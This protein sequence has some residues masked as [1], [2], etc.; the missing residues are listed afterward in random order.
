MQGLHFS[1]KLTGHSTG[2]HSAS[3]L[4]SESLFYRAQIWLMTAICFVLPMKVSFT[5]VLSAF[6][7]TI[8]IVEGGLVEKF[9]KIKSSKLCL[10][11]AAYYLAFLLGMLWTEDI[12]AGWRMVDRQTPFLLFLLYWSCTDPK[13]RERY[14]LAF[15]AGVALCA[16][17][18]HY[19]FLQLH[20]FPDWPRGVR[21]FKGSLDTGPFLDRILYTPILALGAYFCIRRLL[22]ASGVIERIG[23]AAI[24]CLLISNLVFSGGRTGMVM[25]AAMCIALIFERIKPKLKALLLCAVLS[26]LFFGGIFSFGN[27]FAVRVSEGV[28][29]LQNFQNNQNTPVGQRLVYWATS[30]MLFMQNPVIGVGSGDFQQEYA[31][32]KPKQ[33]ESTPDSF[34]PHNQ[35][36]MTATTTGVIGLGLLLYIFYCATR[37]ASDP[38]MY[39]VLIGFAV[40][41]IFESYLWRSNTALTFAVMLVLLTNRDVGVPQR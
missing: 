31:R 14:I 35:F 38:R 16:L 3:R 4:Q 28:S 34:N 1:H 17:L 30:F 5:Y 8:W 25:F 33:W 7:L 22:V 19:N 29:D 40:V 23:M 39:A 24:S 11:F 26:S 13:Y 20:V 9:R 37:L 15:I 10:A 18:A 12:S 41:C 32:I 36:L 2:P 6:L 21:V 27:Y